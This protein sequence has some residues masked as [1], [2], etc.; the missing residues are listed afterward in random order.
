MTTRW[1]IAACVLLAMFASSANAN[2]FDDV[3]DFVKDSQAMEAFKEKLF[4]EDYAEATDAM[5]EANLDAYSAADAAGTQLPAF[6]QLFEGTEEEP[7]E[8][9]L[10]AQEVRNL[11]SSPSFGTLIRNRVT[12]FNALN[13]VPLHVSLQR[14]TPSRH[15]RPSVWGVWSG[16]GQGL[17]CLRVP[18]SAAQPVEPCDTPEAQPQQSELVEEKPQVVKVEERPQVVEV[19][20]HPQVVEELPQVVEEP[21]AEVEAQFLNLPQEEAM[22]TEKPEQYIVEEEQPADQELEVEKVRHVAG[23]PVTRLSPPSTPSRLSNLPAL[24]HI[25]PPLPDNPQVLR[26][27]GPP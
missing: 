12:K 8:E 1:C 18:A 23:Y 27:I 4:D 11:R 20:E 14:K 3:A 10:E 7:E 9:P 6:P 26:P 17:G 25:F 21:Q 5:K 15:K 13:H 16:F 19:E 24:F 22:T 2:L